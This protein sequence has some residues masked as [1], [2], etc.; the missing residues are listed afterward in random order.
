MIYRFKA[1]LRGNKQ[2]Q[3]EYEIKTTATLYDFHNFMVSD[4]AFAPDQLVI[5]RGA[6]ANG[7]IKSEYGLFNMGDGTIDAVSLQECVLKGEV[8]FEY[9][10]DIFNRRS[11]I[12]ELVATEE[13]QPRAEYPR[14]VSER[15]T[16]PD[17]F[18][19]E[20]DKDEEYHASG[21]AKDDDDD[22]LGMDDIPAEE[23]EDDEED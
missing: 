3:R 21:N 4:L 17:Q 5:F 2:F 9:V 22:D 12:L 23:E 19:S 8:K 11:L 10:Y 18:S 16:R 14:L 6:D 13:E 15:G 20:H 7:V 1:T